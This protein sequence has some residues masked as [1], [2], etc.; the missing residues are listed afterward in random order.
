MEKSKTGWERENRSH[1]DEI[2]I[3]Y[4]KARWDYPADLF[5]DIIKYSGP[6]KKRAIEIGAGTG[7][8]TVP[9]LDAGYDVTAVEMGANMAAFLV[10]KFKRQANFNVITTTFEEAS[11]ENNSYDLVY[12]AS[13]FHWVDAE[14]GCPKVFNLLKSGGVFALFRNTAA[15]YDGDKLFDDIQEA[16]DKHYYAHYKP[17]KRPVEIREMTYE[18]FFKPAELY[19]GF[20]FES[21]ERYGFAEITMK[22]YK[23]TRMYDADEYLELLN[24]YSD[25][26]ALPDD[27]RTALYSEIKEAILR[28]GGRCR[29]DNIFQ[30]YMGRKP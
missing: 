23:S 26:R 11:L 7:K 30:L 2:V 17:F 12:A 10:E 14:V 15:I 3:N 19:R 29:L 25:H 1:F 6:G 8:A 24:T 21:L 4:D 20:R 22:L 5:A 18:H 9:F 16:Y 28:H 27:N 13:A